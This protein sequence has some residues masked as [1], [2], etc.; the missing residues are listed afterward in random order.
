MTHNT[1]YS[2]MIRGSSITC[3]IEVKERKG[4]AKY[5]QISRVTFIDGQAKRTDLRIP[6]D[7]IGSFSQAVKEAAEAAV[8]T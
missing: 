1:I 8:T 3:F 2:T 4:G 7:L 6:G 5:M